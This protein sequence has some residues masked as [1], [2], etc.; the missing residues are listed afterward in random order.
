MDISCS[1]PINENIMKFNYIHFQH[2]QIYKHVYFMDLIQLGD[3]CNDQAGVPQNYLGEKNL[4]AVQLTS[5]LEHSLGTPKLCSTLGTW[6]SGETK[7]VQDSSRPDYK[8]C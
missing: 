8:N 1:H 6:N 5:S 3:R 2:S 7:T 4:R